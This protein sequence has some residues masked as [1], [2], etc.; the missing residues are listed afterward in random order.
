MADGWYLQAP[1]GQ[2]TGPFPTEAI[3]QGIGGGHLT[4]DTQ[5]CRVGSSHWVP[6]SEL[7]EFKPALVAR[8]SSYRG[9]SPSYSSISP[10]AYPVS[11][12]GPTRPPPSSDQKGGTQF[13]PHLATPPNAPKARTMFGSVHLSE[14]QGLAAQ[15]QALIGRA[16][17]ADII[18]PYPQVS[19]RHASVG[20]T[21][22]GMI[23]ITDLGSTNG[24]HV[25]GQ[26]APAGQPV[27]VNP[28]EKVF[29]GP[30]AM[31]LAL[32]GD[33][34][35][36]YVEQERA[37]WSGNQVEIEAL[38]LT[39]DV[40]DRQNAAQRRVLL[41]HVTFKSLPGD[42]IAIMGPSGAGKTTLLTVLNGY[43]RPTGG[44]VRVNGENLYAIYDALRG[45]I[46]YVPQDD[47]VHPELTVFEAIKFSA[48]FRLPP[49]FSDAEIDRRVE[50]VM[51]DLGLEAVRDLE[52]GK[53]ERKVLS[54]GQ[55]KRVNIAL[56]LV[57]DPALL[58]LDEP[59][60]GLAAD[61][62]VALIDLL[63][64][65]AKKYGKTILCTIHQPAR[66]E[67]EKF[68]L[69][70]VLGFGGE[71]LYFGPT[72]KASYEFFGR[73][74][75]QKAEAPVDN[76]RDMFDLLRQRED[77]ALS[78]RQFADRPSARLAASQ[79]WR[80][81]FYQQHNPI[82][83][84][85][86]G[87]T[88]QP[89]TPSGNRSPSR[90]SV[91]LI[92]QF[93]LLMARYAIVK[94]R[95]RVGTFILLA[96]APII[97]ALL[98]IVYAAPIK[99]PN[100]WCKQF[101]QGVE[102][103]ALQKGQQV[104]QACLNDAARFP[105]IADYSGAIFLLAVA[106]IWFGTSNA[107]REIVSEQAIYKRERMVNL[108]VVNY[109]LSKFTLLTG[110]CIVQCTVLLGIAS[111]ALGLGNGNPV[112]FLEMLG[113]MILT[114]MS[115][116]ASGLLI[117]TLVVSSEAAMALTPIVL[118]PQ[119]VLGGRMVPMTNKSWLEGLM[120]LMP[121]R[122]AFEGLLSCERYELA[123]SWKTHACVRSGTGVSNGV[124]DCALE[125]LRNATEGAGGM[126]F[127][128]HDRPAVSLAV[129]G[130]M[131]VSAVVAVMILLKRRDSI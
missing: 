22:D 91:P 41:N 59:T 102:A 131:T 79:A 68:N 30:Y 109:V 10:G 19:L 5:V 112:A 29:I 35:R 45:S 110:L 39:L 105:K 27:K 107:A 36:A 40:V 11:P 71:T 122:W 23:A 31:I 118:I 9:S 3:L 95:D 113:Y 67:Y 130:F 96:Q 90:A 48:Q 114:S 65:L 7:G 120:A 6:L 86:Y 126:G 117:S 20:R 72:G 81:E 44:E 54:G 129:L 38:D 100:L 119:V 101:L 76:P 82:Y 50:Q 15:R 16:A 92:L 28:G 103:S 83:Q 8:A 94:R 111:I 52:I 124:F 55:R 127:S 88:R 47:I 78:T 123:S 61:D 43:L 85:M 66:E 21:P 106:A 18:L 49:D 108:S 42:L 53:P 51:K 84:A 121:S 12:R 25:R 80:H 77:D 70:L 98:A 89:G 32:E 58:F 104:T 115:A 60:S 56:E 97:G 75:A 63:A 37:E 116:V 2:S 17:P 26:R 34:I 62:T 57:T 1:G 46:G 69:A 128:T 13:V 4:P 64:D 14:L 74:V 24:T 87:G 93:R 99:A 125:E 33:A 73:Y